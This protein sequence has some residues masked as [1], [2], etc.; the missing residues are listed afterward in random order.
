HY[1]GQVNDKRFPV[2]AAFDHI[3]EGRLRWNPMPDVYDRIIIAGRKYD[4][5]TGVERF[6]ENMK[7]HFPEEGAAIDGYIA[8]VYAAVKSSSMFFASKAV[9]A[10]IGRL[11]GPLM[12]RKFF[13]YSDRTTL[14]TLQSLTRNPELIAVLTG[15]WGDYGLPPGQSSFAMHAMIAEHYFEGAAYPVGGASE[16][17][18]SIAPVIERAGGRIVISADVS[19]ILL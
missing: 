9:P 3:T 4:F 12:N 8:A 10:T 2:R 18:A 16:I 7:R 19:E 1:I 13:R 17:A 5:P 15:Q 11:I 6:R 14:R